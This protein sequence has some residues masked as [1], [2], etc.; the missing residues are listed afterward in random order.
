ME[1]CAVLVI[2]KLE[3]RIG[4]SELRYFFL[5]LGLL[6]HLKVIQ[7]TLVGTVGQSVGASIANPPQ[8]DHMITT[9]WDIDVYILVLDYWIIDL[10]PFQLWSQCLFE[11]VLRP[12]LRVDEAVVAVEG[13][14]VCDAVHISSVV[15]ILFQI[16]LSQRL[17][18][19]GLCSVLKGF[20]EDFDTDF[21]IYLAKINLLG[22]VDVDKN[23]LICLIVVG[24]I[25]PK[26]V[27]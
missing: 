14:D 2:V 6:N 4:V 22:S 9:W 24:C 7:L 11:P 3:V 23:F 17:V 13:F 8:N 15:W 18:Y 1:D 21:V 19:S 26:R 20:L 12:I 25:I 16:V 10:Q 27:N 5:V